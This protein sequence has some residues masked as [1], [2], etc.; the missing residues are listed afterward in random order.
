MHCR[1]ARQGYGPACM[2]VG[3]LYEPADAGAGVSHHGRRLRVLGARGSLR[4]QRSGL[5]LACLAQR[6]SRCPTAFQAPPMAGR[7]VRPGSPA[8]LWTAAGK[9]GATQF[10]YA[11]PV[12][13]RCERCGRCGRCEDERR[14]KRNAGRSAPPGGHRAPS[15]VSSAGHRKEKKIYFQS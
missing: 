8:R 9:P 1:I 3:T 6:N 4:S 13:E 5:A 11:C 15:Y 2:A 14:K 12:D 10:A 7:P